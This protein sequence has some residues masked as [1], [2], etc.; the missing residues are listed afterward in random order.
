MGQLPNGKRLLRSVERLSTALAKLER[1]IAADGGV[2]ISQLRILSH[3]SRQ[4]EARVSDMAQ[5][6]GLSVSTM[7][8]NVA[9]LCRKGWLRRQ[10]GAADKRTVRVSLTP[11][12]REVSDGLQSSNTVEL[13]NAF[14][15]FHPT[16]RVERAVALDRVAAALEKKVV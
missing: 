3:L 4:G 6:L 7:T 15:A 14:D 5:D 12:G 2:S 13:L 16:D 1:R 8:R 10:V 9:H 11:N